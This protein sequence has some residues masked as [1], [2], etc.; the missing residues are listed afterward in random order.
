[1]KIQHTPGPWQVN[2]G[3]VFTESGAPIANMVRDETATAA[4]IAPWERD[5]NAHLI[6]AAPELLEALEGLAPLILEY[7]PIAEYGEGSTW[8]KARAAIKKAK[9]E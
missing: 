4:G 5:K 9:G 7:F 3:A 1:M 8:A 2:S 6:A